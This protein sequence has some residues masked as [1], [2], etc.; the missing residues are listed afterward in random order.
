VTFLFENYI[1]SMPTFLKTKRWGTAKDCASILMPVHDKI[2]KFGSIKFQINHDLTC[3]LGIVGWVHDRENSDHAIGPTAVEVLLIFGPGQGG[4]TNSLLVLLAINVGSSVKILGSVGVDELSVWAIV[5][6]DSIFGTNDKP[7]DL[8][9]EEEDVDW[10]FGI[11]FIQV[12]SFNKVPNVDLSVSSTR[13]NKHSV[14][15]KI[16]AIDLSLVSN[17]SMHQAHGL[18]V[19]DLD[20]SIPRGRHNDWLLDIVIESDAR[21]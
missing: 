13:G 5:H 16:K 6:S 3:S 12:S 8:G 1:L 7:V 15:S 10:G 9:G 2:S 21:P 11:D 14:L 18:V 20:G 4:A 17:K 19:P